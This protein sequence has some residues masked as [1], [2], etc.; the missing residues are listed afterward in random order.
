MKGLGLL[1]VVGLL[2]V[3]WMN[4]DKLRGV[5]AAVGTALHLSPA[6]PDPA[7][8]AQRQAA[9]VYPGITRPDSALNKKFVALYQDAQVNDPAL[10]SRPDWPFVL[11]ERA[12]VSLGGA[13]LPR[14]VPN[15]LAARTNP[16]KSV[17]IYTSSHCGYCTKAK[18]YFAQKGISYREVSIE[19]SQGRLEF[20]SRGGTG[21]PLIVVGGAKVVNGFDVAELDRALQ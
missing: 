6:T 13:P 7:R 8:E 9:A 3:G 12:V 1:F 21:T 20:R 19:T 18:Q 11:A 2:I 16:A 14:S 10:L 5:P 4:R 17:V 15:A